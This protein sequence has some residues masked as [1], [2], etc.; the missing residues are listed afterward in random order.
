MLP[1]GKI[2][3]KGENGLILEWLYRW[4][5]ERPEQVFLVQPLA[6][7]TVRRWTWAAAADEARR[8]AAYLRA[9][10]WEPGA[11]VGI[12]SKNCAWWLMADF[13]IWMAGYVSVPIY[14]SLKAESVRRILDHCEAK[15]C[16]VGATDERETAAMGIPDGVERIYLPTALAGGRFEWEAITAQVEPIPGDPVG[17]AESLATIIY[18]SGTTGMPK[19]VM[20][21]FGSL[22]FNAQ[23]LTASLGLEPVTR[24]LSYLPLAHIMERVCEAVALLHGWQLFFTAGSDTFLEDLKRARPTL[25][26]TVPRLLVKFQQGVLAK[27]PQPKLELL[28]AIPLV[29]SVVKRKILRQLGLDAVQLAACG[30]APLPED[31]L[32]W[33]RAL[34]LN[35]VEGYG[36]TETMIT[37]VPRGS[38]IRPGY[39][40][41]CLDGV[42]MKIGAEGELLIKS[43]MNML[44]YYKDPEGTV[45]AFTEDGFFR[46]GDLARIGA[47]GQL[48]IVGRLKEQFK[49]S[50]GKY[51]I[52]APIESKL[53]G[54][55]EIESCVLMGAGLPGPVALVVL[56]ADARRKCSDPD[57]R[58]RIGGLL[59]RAMEEVNAALDAH[60]R[61]RM[62]VVAEGPWSIE[63]GLMTPTM[64][65][66]RTSLE[67]LYAPHLEEWMGQGKSVVWE[68]EAYAPVPPMPESPARHKE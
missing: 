20:H 64:K 11:R 55:A 39:V 44:G 67:D 50:K 34:G 54:H 37:H 28:L 4:E 14:P 16:F 6:S 7:G 47:D 41:P 18:T 22:A 43:P 57:E 45:R 13:A 62:I 23:A 1:S 10:G 33:F 2:K 36:M 61:L 66:R 49:T 65:I 19:G 68:G 58:Q 30:A 31:I 8:M 15:G 60:E 27:L 5:R 9:Q 17:A 46:T 53:M 42:S 24:H 26:L 59:E 56:T 29:R 12:L 48:Q 63:N 40:G 38:A 21:S 3:G 35:L 25:F 32:M 52:P 51:V